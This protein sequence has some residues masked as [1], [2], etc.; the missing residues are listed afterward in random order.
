MYELEQQEPVGHHDHSVNSA[1]LFENES[2]NL[3]DLIQ[4]D[5]LTNNLGMTENKLMEEDY[6]DR[7]LT[8]ETPYLLYEN[9]NP[10]FR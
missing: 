4:Q 7:I 9:K 1:E 3:N 2:L 8:Q 10:F 5:D 6:F